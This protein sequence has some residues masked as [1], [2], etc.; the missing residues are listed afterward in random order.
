MPLP[1]VTDQ[2]LRIPAGAFNADGLAVLA[3]QGARYGGDWHVAVTDQADQQDS[4]G[5]FQTEAG[6]ASRK[7][8][9]TSDPGYPY[10][11]IESAF[12]WLIEQ[13]RAQDL[14]VVM[15]TCLNHHY[16]PDEAPYFCAAQAV[17]ADGSFVPQPGTLY[18]DEQTLDQVMGYTS[19]GG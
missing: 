18:A 1:Y 9:L 11:A 14:R 6:G 4:L 7:R 15:F 8:E 12:I 16:G 19:T 10:R 13:T 3:V 17:I 5:R 2:A